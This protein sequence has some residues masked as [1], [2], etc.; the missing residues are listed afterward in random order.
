M[1]MATTLVGTALVG[2]A[3]VGACASSTVVAGDSTSGSGS[4]A[5]GSGEVSGCGYAADCPIVFNAESGCRG[6]E[7]DPCGLHNAPLC[8]GPQGAPVCPTGTQCTATCEQACGQ[9]TTCTTDAACYEAQV[10]DA[11]SHTCVSKPCQTDAECPAN[12]ACGQGMCARRACS[13]DSECQGFCSHGSCVAKL[14]T[15]VRCF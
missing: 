13:Q 9:C 8:N 7:L 11:T 3:L 6:S 2:A 5:G 1:R 4:G 15:C 10:C 12:F 14:G